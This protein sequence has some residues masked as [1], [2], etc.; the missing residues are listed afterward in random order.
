M[1]RFG[2]ARFEFPPPVKTASGGWEFWSSD[3][4][5]HL[6]ID[7]NGSPRVFKIANVKF[8]VSSAGLATKKA[9][10]L[11]A[12]YGL[13]LPEGMWVGDRSL[14]PDPSAKLAG[15]SMRYFFVPW[16]RGYPFLNPGSVCTVQFSTDLG[17][18]IEWDYYPWRVPPV[19]LPSKVLTRREAIA[20]F[21][22]HALKV[23]GSRPG[24]EEWTVQVNERQLDLGWWGKTSP[25]LVYRAPV[26]ISHSDSMGTRGGGRQEVIDAATG[27]SVV[28]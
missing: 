4:R 1:A 15:S 23:I 11:F 13:R 19:H 22:S 12:H 27:A 14:A 21:R 25:R 7:G 28:R 8:E 26:T 10:S 5:F 9:A 17:R 3:E 6:R 18:V 16:A 20:A 2:Y 24:L